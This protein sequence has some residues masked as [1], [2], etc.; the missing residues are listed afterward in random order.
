[1]VEDGGRSQSPEMDFTGHYGGEEADTSADLPFLPS[2]VGPLTLIQLDKPLDRPLPIQSANPSQKEGKVRLFA[3]RPK[4]GEPGKELAFLLLTLA[5]QKQAAH[6]QP[7]PRSP[8]VLPPAPEAGAVRA[9][10]RDRQR[11]YS[12]N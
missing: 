6:F 5:I 3:V 12:I 11:F 4:T 9:N 2:P 8:P 1:M 7:V 10:G